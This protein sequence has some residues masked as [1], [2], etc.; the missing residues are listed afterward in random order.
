MTG[1]EVRP[2][3]VPE[4]IHQFWES[5]PLVFYRRQQNLASISIENGN[6]PGVALE[7]QCPS[8]R[9]RRSSK[10]FWSTQRPTPTNCAL[11]QQAFAWISNL[12]FLGPLVASSYWSSVASLFP[13]EPLVARNCSNRASNP[14]PL[15]EIHA[16]N[17]YT[18]PRW[19]KI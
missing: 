4:V 3:E 5:P 7:E 12:F 18:N 13:V 6:S 1:S 14:A 8:Y 17:R 16:L 11:L 9:Q 10:Q 15:L 19:L 2:T